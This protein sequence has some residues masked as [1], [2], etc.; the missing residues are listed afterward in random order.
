MIGDHDA[1]LPPMAGCIAALLAPPL[2]TTWTSF[3]VQYQFFPCSDTAGRVARLYTPTTPRPGCLLSTT[4]T[5]RNTSANATYVHPLARLSESAQQLR[6][7]RPLLKTVCLAL[8]T[9]LST[10]PETAFA[11]A[12]KKGHRDIKQSQATTRMQTHPS[13]PSFANICERSEWQC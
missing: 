13:S 1:E 3:D 4:S 7:Y 8:R 2:P 5:I 11:A 12:L 9:G 10:I 6:G